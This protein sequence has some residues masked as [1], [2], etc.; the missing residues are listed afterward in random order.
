[1]DTKVRGRG[2]I[3]GQVLDEEARPVEGV[4]IRVR[5]E[6]EPYRRDLFAL[7]S[8]VDGPRAPAFEGQA[9]SD[10]EGRFR[11]TGLEE[12]VRT[13]VWALP[14]PPYGAARAVATP[15]AERPAAVT[16]HLA[17]GSVL[18]GR[19]V[20]AAGRGVAAWID[21]QP[22]YRE[23]H[24][25][26]GVGVWCVRGLGTDAEGRFELVG[27]PAGEAWL[28]AH[29]PGVGSRTFHPVKVPTGDEVVLQVGEAPGATLAGHVRDVAGAPVPNAHLFVQ[30][31]GRPIGF[32]FQEMCGPVGA[33]DAEGSYAIPHLPAGTIQEIRVRAEGFVE[34]GS[35]GFGIPLTARATVP[36]DVVLRRACTLRGRVVDAQGTPL[37]GLEVWSDAMQTFGTP[38]AA[39]RS[40]RVVTDADGAYVLHGVPA[41]RRVVRAV[42]PGYARGAD[43]LVEAGEGGEIAVPDLVLGAS[44]SAAREEPGERPRGAIE[45]RLLTP[46]GVPVGGLYID[47][48]CEGSG[49]R[50]ATVGPGG[51]FRLAG[52]EDGTWSL[53]PQDIRE[54]VVGDTVSVVV[55]GGG[56][57]RGVE[58][59]TW[60]QHVISGVVEDELGE[61]VCGIS[62][63]AFRPGRDWYDNVVACT[64]TDLDG[65]FVL[66]LYEEGEWV[67][68]VERQEWRELVASDTTGLRVVYRAPEEMRTVAVVVEDPSGVPLLDAAVRLHYT[69]SGSGNRTTEMRPGGGRYYAEIPAGIET[70]DLF[71]TYALDALGRPLDVAPVEERGVPLQDDVIVVRLSRGR[72]L[73]VGVE[74]PDGRPVAD[75]WVVVRPMRWSAE[76]QIGFRDGGRGWMRTDADGVATAVGLA[77]H[78]RIEVAVRTD[79]PYADPRPV[80]V[81]TDVER[82]TV[83]LPRATFLSGQVRSTSGRALSGMAVRVMLENEDFDPLHPTP[84]SW[85]QWPYEPWTTTTDAQGRFTIPRVPAGALLLLSAAGR[86]GYLPASLRGVAAGS[87]DVRLVLGE[88]AV[89]RGRCL[90]AA[91]WLAQGGDLLVALFPTDAPADAT[92]YAVSG[93]RRVDDD[94]GFVL[95]TV[96]TG[97]Y[98]L[99]V[100]LGWSTV[101][102]EILIDVPV[103]DLEVRL[104][105]QHLLEVHLEGGDVE[106]FGVSVWRGAEPVGSA[107]ADAAGVVRLPF[108]DD[109]PFDVLAW[110][111]GD[112]RIGLADGVRP[113]SGALTL[114]LAP[115]RTLAGRIE[116]A[117][118]DA[119][120]RFQVQVSSPRVG[121]VVKP[122][123]AG[124]FRV[125][126]LPPG[127]YGVTVHVRGAVGRVE[128]LEGVEAGREDLVLPFRSR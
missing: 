55:E 69:I 104:A 105:T 14:A 127:T 81:L 42:L 68:S 36:F 122:D 98:R 65:G 111:D 106:G 77:Q 92:R 7:P 43:V 90:G 73:R 88:G 108:L 23:Q 8:P 101:L 102:A 124:R 26:S 64:S 1:V 56:T 53:R 95:G 19:V 60:P 39:P 110:R 54:T 49:G 6:W 126:G 46:D 123:A 32:G 75:A 45:G 66:L 10:A 11:L 34:S 21:A 3:A 119:L 115:G 114:V 4:A 125:D 52:V 28:S 40:T 27:V 16:L 100:T 31:Q 94:G 112:A 22:P 5:R 70:V 51:V 41:G 62:V 83:R 93:S 30:V 50:G 118:A 29:A 85:P 82:V 48:A 96:P 72:S 91:P 17:R 38:P 86:D 25:A 79:G 84:A 97:H 18:R 35:L 20:D 128:P 109:G 44:P 33:S 59:R 107:E 9:T 99:V 2:A 61:P 58:V 67:L 63:C 13:W 113:S 121:R 116:G 117:P 87:D 76:D 37:P 103:E 47:A 57:V 78:E 12:G 80:Y 71:V 15:H 24:R 74:G 120:P 89:V